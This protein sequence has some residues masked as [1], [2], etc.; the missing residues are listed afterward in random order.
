MKKI[1]ILHVSGSMDRGGT[2]A[3][4]MNMFRNINRDR[5]NFVFLCFGD[6]KF[7]YEEEVILLGGKIV[8]L[9]NIKDIGPLKYV[10]N[11]KKIITQEHIDI[12][13]AHTYYNSMFPM[14]AAKI[15]GVKVR[16]T[17]S[18]FTQTG[19]SQNPIK[20]IYNKLAEVVISRYSTN[21][22]ACGEEAG[23]S[24]FP[25]KKFR[26]IP[27]GIALKDFYFN[28]KSR[29]DIRKSLNIPQKSIVLGHV[30]R[31]DQQK[32]HKFLIEIYSEY[33]KINSDSHLILVG[34]GTLFDEVRKQV[35]Q[36]E[37]QNNVIFLGKRSNVNE[38]YNAM[39]LF[40]LPSL[41]EG[42]PVT[43]VETQANGL[44]SVVSNTVDKSAKLTKAVHFISLGHDARYWAKK[45]AAMNFSR[46]ETQE[47][48]ESSD[49]NINQNISKIEHLYVNL[50][51]S[52]INKG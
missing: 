28:S 48:L 16:I 24:L 8:R 36:L 13:H 34:T 1:N 2:E 29:E 14:I 7:D 22:L 20:K 18:H 30:G 21:Y 25:K 47:I 5:F 19:Q 40:L 45:I 35:E 9:A 52:E 46:V 37:I 44:I 32:N 6:K 50:L 4:L 3:F 11:I 31:F 33:L 42:L 15:A 26:I 49:Y 27:N 39:D 12:V 17:H 10:T 51:E 23:R 38:L 41:Y 43:V